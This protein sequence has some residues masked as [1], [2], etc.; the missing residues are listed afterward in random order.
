M[1]SSR[2][3]TNARPTSGRKPGPVAE[4]VG[5]EGALGVEPW[6]T[7]CMLRDWPWPWLWRPHQP[8]G[9]SWQSLTRDF[10]NLARPAPTE[11]L[12]VL[13]HM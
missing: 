4:G 3:W 11:Y 13:W 8:R 12:V 6:Y 7:V 2:G 10:A 9:S 1:R 5:E